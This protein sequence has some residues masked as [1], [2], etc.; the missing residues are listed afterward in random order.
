MDSSAYDNDFPSLGTNPKP[1]TFVPNSAWSIPQNTTQPQYHAVP[2]TQ[3]K[4]KISF[5]INTTPKK[6]QKQP[7]FFKANH[8]LP[9][10]TVPP[11]VAAPV[12]FQKP[13]QQYPEA[14]TKYIQR[15]LETVSIYTKVEFKNN[16][17]NTY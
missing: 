15:S 6:V 10:P 1:K 11:P 14:L 2:Q 5:S 12:G 8:V 16:F 4:Q 17:K 3:N 13:Q 7:A 9:V